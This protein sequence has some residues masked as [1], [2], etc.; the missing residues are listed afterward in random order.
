[1]RRGV[2]AKVA[3]DGAAERDGDEV[4]ALRLLGRRAEGLRSQQPRRRLRQQCGR[5]GS[6]SRRRSELSDSVLLSVWGI[7]GFR[8]E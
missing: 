7:S 3:L 5:H 2:T 8:S 4:D 6:F 1:V